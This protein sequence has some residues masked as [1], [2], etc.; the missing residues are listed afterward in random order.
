MTVHMT[1]NFFFLGQ[2]RVEEFCTIK[3]TERYLEFESR[4]RI[5]KDIE[6]FIILILIA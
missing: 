5:P 4:L 2:V 3:Q 1:V 6:L